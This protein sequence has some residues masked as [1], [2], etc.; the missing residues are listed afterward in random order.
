MNV[1][2]SE[3]TLSREHVFIIGGGGGI[4]ARLAA[5]LHARGATLCLAG[6]NID[7]LDAVAGPL[8]AR[9]VTLDATRLDAVVDAVAAVASEQPITGLVNLAGAISL[10]PVSRVTDADW[11][12]IVA[13]NL[14]TAFATVRAASSHLKAGASVVLVS[15]TAA[16]IGLQNHEAVAATKAGVEGLVR[17]AAASWARKGVRINAVA[18]GLTRTPLAGSLVTD[19]K[20]LEASQRMHPMQRIGEPDDIAGAIAFLLSP[21]SAWMTGQVLAVDGGLSSVKLPG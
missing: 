13:Q 21:A 3:H 16:R 1:S 7:R 15:S 8:G 17:S 2:D 9:T 18:P 14:T 4:G 20:L 10:K 11:T 6:R 12:E 5:T 19:P